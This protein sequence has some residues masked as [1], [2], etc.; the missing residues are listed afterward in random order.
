MNPIHTEMRAGYVPPGVSSRDRL[1]G[2]AEQFEA[3][4][5]QQM[6]KQMRKAS[7]V[8]SADSPLRSRQL[9]T[10][11]DYHDQALAQT[12]ASRRQSG[13]ADLLVRQLSAPEPG[14]ILQRHIETITAPAARQ[15]AGLE[16]L[17]DRVIHQESAGQVG[18]VSSKGALGLMQLMPDTAREV[19]ARLNLPY[20]EQRLTRDGAYN[21]RLGSAYLRQM[22]ERYQ[23]EPAL[24]LA[25]YNAGPARVDEWLRAYGDPRHGSISTAAWIEQIPFGET[26]DYTR[27]VIG[28]IGVN[29]N[30]Q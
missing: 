12:L 5:L 29:A 20:D 25:A 6:L 17:V 9:D 22:L 10:L 24:A 18:A 2:A 27:R 8:L 19:A 26:R 28:Q 4:F 16:L 13:I 23:G 1:H 21:R 15:P 11:R 30:V 3:L 14:G 7:D